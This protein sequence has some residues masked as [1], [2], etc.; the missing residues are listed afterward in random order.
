MRRPRECVEAGREDGGGGGRGECWRGEGGLGSAA[1]QPGSAGDA[2]AASLLRQASFTLVCAVSRI[3][4]TIKGRNPAKVTRQE[5]RPPQSLARVTTP[6]PTQTLSDS[7]GRGGD[8]KG[9]LEEESFA[10]L[11]LH[12][13]REGPRSRLFFTSSMP[14]RAKVLSAFE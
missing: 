12:T 2:T 8:L 3:S 5:S 6:T 11:S 7:G 4:W 14:P 10:P 13:H 9:E 1:P